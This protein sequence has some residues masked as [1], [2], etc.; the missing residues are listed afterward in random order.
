MKKLDP[1]ELGKTIG[2]NYDKYF[3]IYKGA[4][5]NIKDILNN[6]DLKDKEV[7]TVLASSDQAIS[8]FYNGSKTIDTFDRNYLT[9][10]YYYLRKWLILYKNE[11]YPSYKFLDNAGNGDKE[12][13]DLICDIKPSSI[14][15]KEAKSFWKTFMEYNHN[16]ANHLMENRYLNEDKPFNNVDSI[17]KSFYDKEINFKNLDITKQIKENK[18][19]DVVYLSN[20]LEYESIEENRNTI[21]INLEHLLKDNGIVI[22]TYKTKKKNDIWHLE[23]INELTKG[24]LILDKECDHYEPLL[25]RN[26]ELA[27]S[28]K[29]SIK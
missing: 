7:F 10:Y 15:E 24:N 12:L 13:Y 4:N 28:Y 22:C 17:V 27:Y 29:K 26:K 3:L 5:E 8:F 25:G 11:L 20:M 19:Y 18:K 2:Q 9:L 16:K 21:R 23:E 14:N 6:Y 1:I